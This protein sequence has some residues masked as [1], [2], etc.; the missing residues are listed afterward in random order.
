MLRDL[1]K[2]L[3]GVRNA[4]AAGQPRLALRIVW[5]TLKMEW[6][7]FVVPAW[8][9]VRFRT[10]RLAIQI[11]HGAALARI[12]IVYAARRRRGRS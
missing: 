2:A 3:A 1:G 10:R 11:R 8:H 9:L 7:T 12:R 5:L 4:L 6:L